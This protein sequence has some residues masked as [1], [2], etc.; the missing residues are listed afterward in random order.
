MDEPNVDPQK[1][2]VTA[3]VEMVRQLNGV[4]NTKAIVR[5]QFLKGLGSFL[6]G[7]GMLVLAVM[8]GQQSRQNNRLEGEL[9]CRFQVSAE[10]SDLNDEVDRITGEI[11]LAAVDEDD[12]KVSELTIELRQQLAALGTAVETRNAA[13]EERCT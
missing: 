3:Q 6:I 1:L 5:V 13:A 12:A 8:V 9:D 2:D 4:P 7:V 10:V 11:I